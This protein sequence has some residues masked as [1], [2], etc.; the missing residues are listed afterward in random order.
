MI[1][2]DC[3]HYKEEEISILNGNDDIIY[4]GLLIFKCIKYQEELKYNEEL[5]KTKNGVTLKSEVIGF[6][7]IFDCINEHEEL[8]SQIKIE[9]IKT[10]IWCP[11]NKK[12]K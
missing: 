12:K 9:E 4:I 2:K 6:G 1:C 11:L 7:K 3:E 8:V 10:P 5:Y